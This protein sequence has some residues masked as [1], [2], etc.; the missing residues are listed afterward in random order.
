MRLSD[1]RETC[2]VQDL[3]RIGIADTAK[4][5]WVGQRPLEGVVFEQKTLAECIRARIEDLEPS[6][7]ECG[8]GIIAAHNM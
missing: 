7:V 6:H 2:T 1:R 8:N 4:E 5:A 3:V